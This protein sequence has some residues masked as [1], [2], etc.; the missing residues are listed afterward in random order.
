MVCDNV[1]VMGIHEKLKSLLANEAVTMT[2]VSKRLLQEKN[3]KLSMNNLSRKLRVKTIK[4]VE[5]EEILDLLGYD[6]EF[7]KR[8]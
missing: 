4:Y 1:G 6:I 8:K 3:Y 2:Q 7:K 5:V